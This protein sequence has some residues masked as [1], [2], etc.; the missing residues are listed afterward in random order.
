MTIA[1]GL[2]GGVDS[3]TTAKMLKE[4]G[5]TVFGVTMLNWDGLDSRAP[6]SGSC[7]GPYQKKV[8]EDASR[9][10]LDIGID[11]YAIDVSKYFK[12]HVI[13][14]VKESY[15]KGLTP[16]PCIECNSLVKFG[17]LF[18]AINDLGLKFDKF[19]TG[20]YAGVIF[21]EETKRYQL[22][23]G[24]DTV[25]DQSYFL[26]KLTQEQLSKIIFPMYNLTKD[27]VRSLAKDY[28]LEVF[29]KTDSQDFFAGDYKRLFDNSK[30]EGNIVHIETNQILKQHDGIVNF[31]IGQRK[32]LDIAYSEALYVVKID[33]STNTVYVGG[34]NLKYTKT[35]EIDSI[36]W[37][38]I[39][40]T[41][42]EFR[43]LVKTRSSHK[44]VMATIVPSA[45]TTKA[46]IIFDTETTVIAKGQ[47][48]VCYDGD[49]LLMGGVVV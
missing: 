37:V 49:V 17:A 22:L 19:A 36:N 8:V 23:K 3:T 28:N 6:T 27:K 4:E 24:K 46:N 47:S 44:G 11:Y 5:H 26:Y 40:N 7:Y 18:S 33:S 38:S 35:C 32:G 43:A 2:S 31:T 15:I 10:A 16:N 41:N 1:V 9:Y 20:H 45:C 48:S 39:A 42:K 21:N 12:E 34:A 14:Y 29:D 13:N 25:K 30:T